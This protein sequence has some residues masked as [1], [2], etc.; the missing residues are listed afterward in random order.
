M[1]GAVFEKI[2][3]YNFHPAEWIHTKNIYHSGT[4]WGYLVN[5]SSSCISTIKRHF[6]KVTSS[7]S[8]DL[9]MSRL[10]EIHIHFFEIVYPLEGKS[11]N[12]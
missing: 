6:S 7:N 4:V 3:K 5:L 1:V 11:N 2:S 12:N 10:D 9:R 8:G